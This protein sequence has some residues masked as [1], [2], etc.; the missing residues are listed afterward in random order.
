MPSD[1]LESW[2]DVRADAL[3]SLD[4]VHGTVTGRRVG[5]QY[6]TRH[7]NLTMYVALAAEFQGFCRDL[8]DDT[9]AAMLW[10]VP[11]S[12]GPMVPIF[13]NSLT[14]ARQL[15]RG[16]AQPKSLGSDFQILGIQLWS[17]LSTLRP[18]SK[19]RWHDTLDTLNDIRNAVAHSDQAKLDALRKKEAL[20]VRNWRRKRSALNQLAIYMDKVAFNY[21]QTLTGAP[22]W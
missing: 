1:A 4:A 20:D 16:N 19:T 14:R 22:P 3:E 5:R 21:L 12:A 2:N 17:D 7:Y 11:A 18:G 9:A 13:L 10:H 8:H 15:D 6:A